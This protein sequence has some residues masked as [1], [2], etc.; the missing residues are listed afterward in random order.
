MYEN[1]EHKI[2]PGCRVKYFRRSML[3]TVWKSI[4]LCRKLHTIWTNNTF[5]DTS[6]NLMST[7]SR[8][9][10]KRQTYIWGIVTMTTVIFKN[11]VFCAKK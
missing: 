3:K 11:I 4:R 1:S 6:N 9:L 8:S 2:S 5:N 10:W 7:L